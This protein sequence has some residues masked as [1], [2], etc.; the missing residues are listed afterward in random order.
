[1]NEL[2][3]FPVPRLDVPIVPEP[4]PTPNNVWVLPLPARLQFLTTLLVAP[5]AVA[6]CSQITALEVPVLVLVSV[7][8]REATEGGQTV[9]DVVPVEPSMV[10]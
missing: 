3:L 5:S 7:R 9:F 8:S 6:V 2:L 4:A 1:M 10:T